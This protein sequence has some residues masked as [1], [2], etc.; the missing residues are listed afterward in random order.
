MSWVKLGA[1]TMRSIG[2]AAALEFVVSMA[3]PALLPRIRKPHRAAAAIVMAASITLFTLIPMPAEVDDFYDAYASHWAATAY[4]VV[5]YLG[6]IM[7]VGTWLFF[8][9]SRHTRASSLRIGLQLPATGTAA[10]LAYTALRILQML[11]PLW[12]DD[13][14]LRSE[15]ISNLK[16]VALSLV[17]TGSSIPAC[18][19]A[20]QTLKDFRTLLRLRSLWASLNGAVP[21]I[22]LVAQD[23]YGP[24][25]LLHRLIIEIRDACLA[26]T[27]YGNDAVR[28]VHG[29]GL[30]GH[31]QRSSCVPR[32]RP[33][34]PTVHPPPSPVSTSPPRPGPWTST[35]KSAGCTTA[36]VPHYLPQPSVRT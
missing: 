8:S 36:D 31:Q 17:L 30:T 9:Y 22:V 12:G 7:A 24:R 2:C 20:Y 28:T 25:L 16:W 33:R 6:T 13:A 3:R 29:L 18:G 15:T 1:L 23:T 32:T 34:L 19:V 10:G 14:P 11:W 27:P 35:P 26:L 21:E 5:G 4:S